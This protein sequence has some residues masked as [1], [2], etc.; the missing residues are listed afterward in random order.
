MMALFW[1]QV[2][3]IYDSEKTDFKAAQ[4]YCEILT[5]KAYS[6]DTDTG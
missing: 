2:K 3:G 1:E 5:N 4:K 6:Q